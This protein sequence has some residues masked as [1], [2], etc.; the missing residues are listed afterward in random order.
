MIL[1]KQKKNWFGVVQKDKLYWIILGVIFLIFLLQA[2]FFVFY[3]KE[4]LPPDEFYHIKLSEVYSKS[5]SIPS[6]SDSTYYLGEI[7]RV[8]FLYHWL[9]GRVLNIKG[10]I[11]P[12]FANFKVLRLVS[13]VIGLFNVW[14]G[15][16]I[17]KFISKDKLVHILFL[18][19]LTNTLMF[20]FMMS[21]VSYDPLSM[22]FTSLVILFSLKIFKSHNIKL[23]SWI[24][25]FILLG[26]I[27]KV[28]FIPFAFVV[29]FFVFMQEIKYRKDYL[30]DI[31]RIVAKKK[32]LLIFL[33]M[34]GLV[35][36]LAF[37]NINLY[38]TNLIKYHN[39][40]PSC[41][42][43]IGLDKCMRNVEFANYRELE[44]LAPAKESLLK[45]FWYIPHWIYLMTDRAYGIF[46]HLKLSITYEYFITYFTIFLLGSALFI[47]NF[48]KRKIEHI[49]F[50][51]LILSYT[52]VL[53]IFTNYS[54]Y[55]L[56][57]IIH[58]AV[59]G[60]YMFPVI[61]P[62]YSLISLSLLSFKNNYIKWILFIIIVA[63]FMW[64]NIPFFVKNITNEWFIDNSNGIVIIELIKK[65][66]YIIFD[67]IKSLFLH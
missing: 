2:L 7:S 59:Q 40:K 43:V 20:V 30:K 44:K 16:E 52:L 60:R 34:F 66:F 55:K 28:T 8:P 32:N 41:S 37:L 67:N 11:S 15:L 53:M 57:G 17:V 42:V 18:S 24:I 26:N 27:S 58:A 56:H 49:F 3:I 13:V 22:L 23:F 33:T 63:I 39:I 6:N 48:D 51:I 46:A 31:K 19:M 62:L 50:S 35:V 45:L 47:R 65:Y 5:L 54:A 61:I 9:A 38:G 1:D 29:T 4:N 14:I 25:I 64:G 36:F 12:N 21:S 10:I